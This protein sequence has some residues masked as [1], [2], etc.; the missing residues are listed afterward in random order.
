MFVVHCTVTSAVFV[1]CLLN[2]YMCRTIR[3]QKKKDIYLI[4][5]SWRNKSKLIIIVV[6]YY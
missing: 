2:L 4:L 6:N 3:F 5:L 1:E